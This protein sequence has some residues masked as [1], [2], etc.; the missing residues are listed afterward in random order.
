M[1]V[2]EEKGDEEEFGSTA[3]VFKQF[4]RSRYP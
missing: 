2:D 3:P 1:E 4:Q